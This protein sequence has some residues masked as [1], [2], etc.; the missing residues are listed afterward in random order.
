LALPVA[1]DLKRCDDNP[2]NLLLA[3]PGSAD[4]KPAA[5]SARS[6]PSVK[7]TLTRADTADNGADIRLHDSILVL[8]APPRRRC[9]QANARKIVRQK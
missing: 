2:A 3:V 9:R 6:R 4:A 5:N 8:P 1:Y 7:A